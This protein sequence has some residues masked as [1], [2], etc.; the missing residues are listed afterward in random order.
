MRKNAGCNECT[1]P[2]CRYS[3][4]HNGICACYICKQGVFVLDITSMPKYRLACNKFVEI[5]FIVK[6][7]VYLKYWFYFRCPF[8]LSLPDAI[9]KIT[10][11]EGEFCKQCDTALMD[12]EFNKVSYKRF[13]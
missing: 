11:K 6:L 3:L 9:Q 4:G 13:N 2:T 1:H 12:V 10:M 8:V 7:I 5:L